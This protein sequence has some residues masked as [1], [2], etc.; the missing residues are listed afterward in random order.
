MSTIDLTWG[1]EDEEITV[2]YSVEPADP[3]VGIPCAQ[4]W[5][6]DVRDTLTGQP[7]T[8]ARLEAEEEALGDHLYSRGYCDPPERDWDAVADERRE[9]L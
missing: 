4:A 8:L 5:I 1:S 3:N 9:A 6:V 7:W 2:I